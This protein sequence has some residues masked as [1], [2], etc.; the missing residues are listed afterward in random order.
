MPIE[1]TLPKKYQEEDLQAA[2]TF[3]STKKNPSLFVLL[4][5]AVTKLISEEG[6]VS[7]EIQVEGPVQI[8]FG[9]NTFST[10][11]RELMLLMLEHRAFNK[12]LAGYSI[13]HHDPS[14]I[15]RAMGVVKEQKVTTFVPQATYEVDLK[16]ARAK[17]LKDRIP[18]S[19]T[20]LSGV[21]E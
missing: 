14:G 21:A 3:L 8:R 13:D 2:A 17:D 11:N 16:A 18:E 4:K 5:S 15:W 7:R 10:K 1:R 12:H 9:G 6:G 20:P 19:V